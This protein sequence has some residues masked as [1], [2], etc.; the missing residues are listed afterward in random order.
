MPDIQDYTSGKILGLIKQGFRIFA[1]INIP[2]LG[3]I[4]KKYGLRQLKKCHPIKI[5]A[6]DVSRIIKTSDKCAVGQRVCNEL[7]QGADFGESVF[8]DELATGL[9]Q[10]GKARFV[11]KEKAIHTMVTDRKGPIIL[12]KVSGKHMELC[13][14]LPLNCIYWNSEKNG[15]KCIQRNL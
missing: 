2:L 4:F 9:V 5:Q 8:L 14:S 7:Y 11:S 1:F 15:L 6:A 13:R 3:W 10:A 12:T